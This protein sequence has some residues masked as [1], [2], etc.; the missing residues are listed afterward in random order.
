MSIVSPNIRDGS[1]VNPD[2]DAAVGDETA[3]MGSRTALNRPA[4]VAVLVLAWTA[5]GCGSGPSNANHTVPALSTSR[6]ASSSAATSGGA[7][8]EVYLTTYSKDDGPTS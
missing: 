5:T 7:I 6:S 8:D 1:G 3:R 4:A 2:A